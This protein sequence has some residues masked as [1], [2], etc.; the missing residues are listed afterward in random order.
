MASE[1]KAPFSVR[2]EISEDK[3]KELAN[4]LGALGVYIHFANFE[5]VSPSIL[6]EYFEGENGQ[7]PAI[8]EQT[9]EE[10]LVSEGKDE[11]GSKTQAFTFIRTLERHAS[12]NHIFRFGKNYWRKP[13]EGCDCP[14]KPAIERP[15]LGSN[16]MP[17]MFGLFPNGIDPISLIE[18]SKLPFEEASEKINVT[19]QDDC[20]HLGRK[21]YEMVQRIAARLRD[22]LNIE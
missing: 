5:V 2:G 10:F 3:L 18:F 14:L 20:D 4:Q 21:R 15:D 7:V 16:F 17:H 9:V 1:K 8:T 13:C 22:D 12:H 11:H 6:I 19:A